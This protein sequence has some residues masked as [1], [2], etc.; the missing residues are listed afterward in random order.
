MVL[1]NPRNK[2]MAEWW[3][4]ARFVCKESVLSFLQNQGFDRAATLTYYCFLSMIPLLLLEVF[5]VTHVLRSSPRAME[6][7][8]TATETVLPLS[9][10]FIMQEVFRL[11]LNASWG[12]LTIALLLWAATPLASGIQNAFQTI[13]KQESKLSFLR[14]KVRD[15]GVVLVLL[16]VLMTVVSAKLIYFGMVAPYLAPAVLSLINGLNKVISLIGG[17]LFFMLFFRLFLPIPLRRPHLVIGSLVT[18]L[19]LSAVGPIFAFILRYNPDYGV[20]FGSMK[21]IFMMFVWVYY[22]F[23][24][25]LLGIEIMAN[26]DRRESLLLRGLFTQGELK[27]GKLKLLSRFVRVFEVGQAIFR[28]GDKGETMFHVISGKVTLSQNGQPI[29][30]M[31]AGEYFGEMAMLLGS[32]RTMDAIAAEP[33]TELVIISKENLTTVMR[34][35]PKIVLLLLQ[36]MAARLKTTNEQLQ[37]RN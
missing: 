26:M 25:M 31:Q 18:L 23:A 2:K 30:V 21:A 24:V 12:L 8:K 20:T 6:L 5:V 32:P 16:A 10:D 7:L 9:G 33:A 11:S 22:S 37:L 13:F 14:S 35:N 27:P 4:D 1:V 29:R 17:L 34:E 36:E 15:L 19:L 28:Q 3:T